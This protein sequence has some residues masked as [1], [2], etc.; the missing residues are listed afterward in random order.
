MEIFFEA[1]AAGGNHVM[2]QIVSSKGVIA[3]G[4]D[5]TAFFISAYFQISRM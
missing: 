3:P 4:V 2:Y 5:L 1:N